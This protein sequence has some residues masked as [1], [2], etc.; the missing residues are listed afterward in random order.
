M[1]ILYQIFYYVIA[2][3]FSGSYYNFI[4]Y[5]YT[6]AQTWHAPNI[7]SLKYS[8]RIN[9][10]SIYKQNKQHSVE[11]L[12]GGTCFENYLSK[13]NIKMDSQFSQE[14][15]SSHHYDLNNKFLI[16]VWHKINK[17]SIQNDFWKFSKR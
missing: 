9:Y 13:R 10:Q 2:R 14:I 15:L 16:L 17:N 11:T 12:F 7:E 6:Q 8:Y 1:A 4:K 5:S 3:V